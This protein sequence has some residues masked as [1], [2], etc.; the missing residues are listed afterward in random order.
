[1]A[2]YLNKWKGNTTEIKVKRG[3]FLMSVVKVK[4]SVCGS[5]N[6]S[7]NGISKVGKQ[8]YICKQCHK[9]SFI[10]D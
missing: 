2:M 6:V 3:R 9:S 7:K 1:M 4:C 10:L 8:Q 5:E